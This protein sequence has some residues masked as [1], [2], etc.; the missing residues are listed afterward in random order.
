[1][2]ELLSARLERLPWQSVSIGT[3]IGEIDKIVDSYDDSDRIGIMGM[4]IWLLL[5]GLHNKENIHK[6]P[7][8]LRYK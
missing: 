3:L 4:S 1:M 6:L 8:D 7:S 2:I 5:F